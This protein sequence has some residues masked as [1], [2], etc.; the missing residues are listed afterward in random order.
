MGMENGG[1]PDAATTTPEPDP[2]PPTS[3]SLPG[4]GPA[5]APL[6]AVL[7]DLV[8]EARETLIFF[9]DSPRGRR[10]RVATRA[11]GHTALAAVA[12]WLTAVAVCLVVWMVSAP[13]VSPISGPLHVGGQLWLLAHHIALG[14]PAGRVAVA[15]LGFTLL[16]VLA[17]YHASPEPAAGRGTHLAAMISGS[18]AGYAVAAAFI[19]QSAGTTDVRP[20]LAQTVVAAACFGAAVPAAVHWRRIAVLIGLPAWGGEA[21]RATGVA[22]AILGAGA[23]ALVAGTVIAHFPE[24]GWPH[25]VADAAGMFALVLA[26]FPNAVGW[27]VGYLAGPGFAV[28]AGTTVS[29]L[30]VHVGKRP[31]FPLLHAVPQV[32]G[33]PYTLAVL[34]VPL[35]AGIAAAAVLRRAARPVRE[36][37][38]QEIAPRTRRDQLHAAAATALA[39]ALAA[40]LIAAASGG[41]LAGGRMAALG[42]SPWRTGAAVLVLVGAALLAALTLP[43]LTDAARTFSVR[44]LVA[45]MARPGACLLAG[46]RLH[47]LHRLALQMPRGAWHRLTRVLLRVRAPPRT[48]PGT[49]PRTAPE[50][51]PGTP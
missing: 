31:D 44:W 9:W 36:D 50:K 29:V 1:T 33:Y 13:P 23:A 19:A 49:E 5:P 43:W 37:R 47:R 4:S 40:D 24:R 28:G 11:A 25:G 8:L 41:P 48:A 30:R 21:A 32:G 22:C 38:D 45:G 46:H 20:D 42:P 3:A 17:L 51:P 39:T 14:V 26:L 34:V 16:L 2:P 35:G 12:T 10:L 15:P 7:R 18:G 27:A 6:A